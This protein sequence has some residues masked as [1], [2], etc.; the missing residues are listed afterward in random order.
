M[1]EQELIAAA[2]SVR[3]NAYAPYS[4]FKVGAAI[5]TT[6]GDLFTGCNVENSSYGLAICAERHAIG[7]M[8]AAGQTSFSKIVVAATPLASPC[9]AC[10]QFIVEFGANIEVVSVDANK[11][12]SIKRWPIVELIPNYFH[13]DQ[14]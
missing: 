7:A 11:S 5:L 10:R 9:G 3:E 6:K 13:F 8:V 4:K 2:L 14:L 1:T 12:E